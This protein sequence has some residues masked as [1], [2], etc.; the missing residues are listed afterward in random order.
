MVTPLVSPICC[1][2]VPLLNAAVS[3]LLLWKRPPFT[4]GVCHRLHSSVYLASLAQTIHSL[5]V[6]KPPEI[7]AVHLQQSVTCRRKMTTHSKQLFWFLFFFLSPNSKLSE[8]RWL[9]A[10]LSP[11]LNSCWTSVISGQWGR[12]WFKRNEAKRN[13]INFF[14]YFYIRLSCLWVE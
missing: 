6:G 1:V 3:F 9:N 14:I 10:K 2:M 12:Q 8:K 4:A 5:V 11:S 13:V 7:Y